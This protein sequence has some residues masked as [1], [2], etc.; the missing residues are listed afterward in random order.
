MPLQAAF[1]GQSYALINDG[2]GP[3]VSDLLTQQDFDLPS[4]EG[5]AYSDLVA[6]QAGWL[7]A[8]SEV[9]EDGRSSL[10]LAA[11][12][13]DGDG[14]RIIRGFLEPE[15]LLRQ[16]AIILVDSGRLAGL[17]WLEGSG[18]RQ[19]EVKA[20]EWTG[21]RWRTPRTVSAA[22]PGS[23]LALSG[24]VLADGSWL[25]TWSAFDGQDDEIVWSRLIG[26]RWSR[27][28]PI[29]INN[30]V[31]DVTP[32]VAP[33]GTGAFAAWS[34]YTEGHYQLLLA[35]FDGHS[36]VDE[37]TLGGPGTIF[38]VF[39]PET[40]AGARLLFRDALNRGWSVSEVDPSGVELRRAHVANSS[41]RRPLVT[42]DSSESLRFSWD[43]APGPSPSVQWQPVSQEPAP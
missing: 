18:R 34:R 31:P 9:D 4:S 3:V 13:R 10:F 11:P 37:R 30:D 17:A 33:N 24:A 26:D 35:R 15:T 43:R 40:D 6:T 2:S 22:G 7:A 1:G 41:T 23:Q 38:P 29:S 16:G 39:L 14:V 36:W 42:A 25:L 12:N 20:L 5:V 27:P 21:K 28:Q 19:L 8:G 32:A